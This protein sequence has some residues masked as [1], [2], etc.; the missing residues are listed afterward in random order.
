MRKIN[1]IT[2]FF[3]SFLPM[4][5]VPS[6]GSEYV[7]AI[8]LLRFCSI[9]VCLSPL[10]ILQAAFITHSETMIWSGAGLLFALVVLVIAL[11]NEV[12]VRVCQHVFILILYGLIFVQLLGSNY[13]LDA[14]TKE[15]IMATVVTF[16]LT[17]NRGGWIWIGIVTTGKGLIV[18]M[19]L[20]G[21]IM[22]I[23]S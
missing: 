1:L 3:N 18:T 11:K 15:S 8:M 16:L 17:G 22:R 10:I 6:Q 21:F 12:P 2:R 23:K 19:G 7:E 9:F 5:I 4:R 13:N 20:F 14:I